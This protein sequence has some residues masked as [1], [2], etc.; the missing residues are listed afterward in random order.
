MKFINVHTLIFELE[1][2]NLQLITH[3]VHIILNHHFPALLFQIFYII[4]I[5]QTKRLHFL[6]RPVST[7]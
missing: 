4:P 6:I 7:Y 5:K 2:P 3:V 1:N